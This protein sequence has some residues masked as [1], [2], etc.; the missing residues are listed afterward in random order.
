MLLLAGAIFFFFIT[1]QKRLLKKELELNRIKSEQQK[2]ILQNTILAQEKERNRVARDLH[3][4][5]S[6]MLSVVKMNIARIEKKTESSSSKEL[7]GETKIYVDELI[8]QVRRISHALLPPTLEKLGLFYALNE[9]LNRINNS[10]QFKTECRTIGEI[11]RFDGKKELAVF[12]I[13]Q[14]LLNNSIKHSGALAIIVKC[15]FA[16]QYFAVSVSDNGKGFD[17]KEEL[18]TGLGLKNL[19]S[20]TQ[21]LHARFKIKSSPGK[22]TSAILIFNTET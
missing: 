18:H 14:E 21:I 4:E 20:R 2:E 6:A 17:M 9:L 11:R 13:I 19:E 5:V 12:R 1:Y 15:R 3:D 10:G 7:A 16:P 8:N 22:G